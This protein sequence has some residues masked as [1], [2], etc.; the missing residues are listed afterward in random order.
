MAARGKTVDP[1]AITTIEEWARAYGKYS[2]IVLDNGTPAV[3]DRVDKS[4]VVKRLPL[5]KGDDLYVV[6]QG[7]DGLQGNHGL[8]GGNGGDLRN[9]AIEALE[10]KEV[11]LKT[12]VTEATPGFIEAE[13]QLLEATDAWN[14]ARTDVARAAAALEV[15]RRSVTLVTA[16]HVLRTAA[17][18]RRFIM[19]ISDLTRRDLDYRT[20]DDR[21]MG[22]VLT[23]LKNVRLNAEDRILTEEGRA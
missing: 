2:N 16:D 10:E 12:A 23:S 13:K 11:A 14:L 21:S 17:A 22:N 6:L 9:I 5:K 8:Q 7:S 4:A 20:Q 19:S 3:L 1:A 18:P 15:G